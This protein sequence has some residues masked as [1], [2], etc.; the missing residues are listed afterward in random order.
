MPSR[1]RVV[2][3]AGEL[4]T[5]TITTE[6]HEGLPP[7]KGNAGELQRAILN[8][9]IDAKDAM[10]EG[11]ALKVRTERKA[12]LGGREFAMVTI[13]DTGCGI[14]EGVRN[15]VFEPYFTTKTDKKKLGMGLYLVQKVIREHDGFIELASDK[16]K[17]TTFVL[18]LPLAA[19]A[20]NRQRSWLSRRH[21]TGRRGDL[22][23]DDEEVVRGLLSGVLSAEGFEVLQARDGQKRSTSLGPRKDRLTWSSS[24]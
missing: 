10:P 24:I 7:I 5:I 11:G 18:Y 16:E 12:Y 2:P 22:V 13:E 15:R 21:R 8:L 23:V 9:C 20:R 19:G 1:R 3:Y 6:F 14:D 4:P 17:G